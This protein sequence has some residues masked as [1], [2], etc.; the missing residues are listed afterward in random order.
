MNAVSDRS[1]NK[2]LSAALKTGRQTS[3]S[4]LAFLAEYFVERRCVPVSSRIICLY[5]NV[6]GL[7]SFD[8]SRKDFILRFVLSCGN[9]DV[10]FFDALEKPV[11]WCIIKTHHPAAKWQWGNH[12]KERITNA[13]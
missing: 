3:Y 10:D 6:T 9:D 5:K 7:L 13:Y 4:V 1:S 11:V 8:F 2:R 12:G